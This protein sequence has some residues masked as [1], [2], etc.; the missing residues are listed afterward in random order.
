MHLSQLF[1]VRALR[2][3]FIRSAQGI[4]GT[5][6][7]SLSDSGRS[8]FSIRIVK[9]TAKEKS[10]RLAVLAFFAISGFFI[11]QRPGGRKRQATEDVA[12]NGNFAA[13]A[14]RRLATT[15]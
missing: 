2:N 10:N 5:S 11:S 1:E 8:N 14:C 9:L 13:I 4:I 6:C 12:L 7:V 3:K 15:A